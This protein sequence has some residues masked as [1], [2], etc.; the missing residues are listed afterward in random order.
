MSQFGQLEDSEWRWIRSSLEGVKLLVSQYSPSDGSQPI[1]A[2]VLDR[3]WAAWLATLGPKGTNDVNQINYVINTIAL[4]FG[5]LIVDNYGF[6]WVV[7][8]G[9][10]GYDMA[11]LALPGKGDVV[12]Y[13]LHV[14]A[15][16]WPNRETFF[17]EAVEL[18]LETAKRDAEARYEKMAEEAATRS[19]WPGQSSFTI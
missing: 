12:S 14:V 7:S 18:M 19:A 6:Q 4:T 13:P 17:L 11:V 9:E 1:T 2:G 8:P 5:Q 16:R 15:G 10:N 3:T